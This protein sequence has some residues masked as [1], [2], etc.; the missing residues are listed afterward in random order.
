MIY[1]KGNVKNFKKMQK[2][3]D[4]G[5]GKWYII[6]AFNEGTHWRKKKNQKKSKKVK[7]GLTWYETNDILLVLSKEKASMKQKNK[8]VSK[9]AWL[10]KKKYD[11]LDAFRK[12][13][14]WS[15]KTEQNVNSQN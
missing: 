4:R 8:K 7:K 2:R 15:L 5:N 12:G 14:E 11:I 6:S 9:K 1:C 10:R 13:M 3:L